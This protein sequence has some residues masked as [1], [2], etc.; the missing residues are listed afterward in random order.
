MAGSPR[1]QSRG[2]VELSPITVHGYRNGEVLISGLP[3]GTLVVTAG[4][5]EDGSGIA[6]CAA[7]PANDAYLSR[8]TP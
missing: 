3:A 6:R 5:A 1:G 2:A 8:V 7:G 4:S